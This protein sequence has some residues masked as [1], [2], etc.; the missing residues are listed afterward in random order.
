MMIS[1]NGKPREISQGLTIK[2]LITELAV[3][4]PYAVELN[5]QVC[6]KKNH[7]QTCL[8]DGDVVEIV[9]IVGGG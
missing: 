3:T 9:T 8:K 5:R 6:P 1:V 7:E 4:G 2:G